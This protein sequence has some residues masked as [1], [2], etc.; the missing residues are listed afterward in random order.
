MSAPAGMSASVDDITQIEGRWN[1]TCVAPYA[2]ARIGVSPDSITWTNVGSRL[3]GFFVPS[4]GTGIFFRTQLQFG[5][6]YVS[7]G[8]R[9][10]PAFDDAD[11]MLS[12]A[13]FPAA[14]HR[15]RNRDQPND[16]G[17]QK[18]G[19][20]CPAE[21]VA[22]ECLKSNMLLASDID[23][24]ALSQTVRAIGSRYPMASIRSALRPLQGAYPFDVVQSETTAETRRGAGLQ[25]PLI[26]SPLAGPP[27]RRAKN[28]AS[29]PLSRKWMAA[30]A[31]GDCPKPR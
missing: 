13:C 26:S 9:G 21:I 31:A 18:M 23:T 3:G 7:S 5:T 28:G 8:R 16:G 12:D 20:A 15:R 29:P 14:L 25:L 27:G 10:G 17:R 19:A 11:R 6:A 4:P 30:P 24:S 2:S 1:G 22:S